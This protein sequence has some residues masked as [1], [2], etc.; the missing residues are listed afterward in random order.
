MMPCSKPKETK[1]MS[2]RRK[3][4]KKL[5]LAS[6]Q[7]SV[8]INFMTMTFRMMIISLIEMAN[9]GARCSHTRRP[10]VRVNQWTTFTICVQRKIYIYI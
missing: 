3:H 6:L 8:K 7:P 5:N 4:F 9:Y 10:V 1:E 2:K